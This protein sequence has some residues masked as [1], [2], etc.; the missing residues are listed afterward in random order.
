MD[1]IYYQR[2]SEGNDFTLGQFQITGAKL[3]GY[4]LEPAGPSTKEKG[5]DR[6]IPP[7][8]YNLTWHS[9]HK[10]NNV[11]KLYNADVPIERAILIHGGNYAKDTEGCLLP[12]TG[13]SKTYVTN[14]RAML[15]MLNGFIRAKGVRNVRLVIVEIPSAGS[16]SL[17]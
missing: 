3:R 17:A 9:G 15:Q 14:S 12:G 2:L 8:T 13:A 6:R 11:V 1:H 4:F 10:Y 16:S 7:G 5:T